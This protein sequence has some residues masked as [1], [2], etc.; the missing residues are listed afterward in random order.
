M[1]RPS[2][3]GRSIL[4]VEDEPLIVMDI[5]QAFEGTGAALTTTNTLKHALI[6]VE[7]D[8][9]AGAILDHA[10]GDENSSL[11]C[12]RLK[13]RGIPFLLY[14]GYDTV[15]GPCK[16]ALH[17]SKPA[18]DGALVAAM[19]GLIRGDPKAPTAVNPLL[20]E[21]RRLGDEYRVVEKEIAELRN[22][23]TVSGVAIGD[24]ATMEEGVVAR[25]TD[26]MLLR[27][28]MLELDAAVTV[29]S[30]RPS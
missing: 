20:V 27:Q 8:G 22:T 19:E 4:I 30:L 24:R 16:D 3:E 1:R 11:V 13:E 25:T 9:L 12:Q 10:L 23:L 5:T 6:L 17:I 2:L 18:A 15:E 21:Q 7:H 28:R 26:L 29:A 14:S